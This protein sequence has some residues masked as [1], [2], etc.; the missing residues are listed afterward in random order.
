MDNKMTSLTFRLAPKGQHLI[1][2][3]GEM[4]GEQLVI[5]AE[6][7]FDGRVYPVKEIGD[8][9]FA[10]DDN[11]KSVI[12]NEVTFI[13][14]EAF[15][16]CKNLVELLFSAPITKIE[17]NAFCNCRNLKDINVPID[18]LRIGNWAFAYCENITKIQLSDNVREIGECAFT[19]CSKLEEINIPNLV[20]S[21]GAEAFSRCSSLSSIIIPDSV[22]Y[23]GKY[24]FIGCDNLK[25]VFINK[26]KMLR[27]TAVSEGVEILPIDAEY[28]DDDG[29]MNLQVFS[30]AMKDDE[31]KAE[32]IFKLAGE[33]YDRGYRK[34]GFALYKKAADLG[35]AKAQHIVAFCYQYGLGTEKDNGAALE[36]YQKAAAQGYAQSISYI[37]DF[38]YDGIAGI[39]RD[40]NMAVQLWKR[41]AE[42]GDKES[43]Y[44]LGNLY[45]NGKDVEQDREEAIRWYRRSAQQLFP[46][47]IKRMRELGEWIFDENENKDW[48]KPSYLNHPVIAFP[49]SWFS[50]NY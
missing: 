10:Y 45:Y 18:A 21:I 6:Q 23:T 17:D 31:M 8:S 33:F 14:H 5:P 32:E 9:A 3:G 1:V 2:T 47:A 15:A 40:T 39:K 12:M 27:D 38:Y 19:K 36:W 4:I 29:Q 50:D 34:R 25:K 35:Y 11:L 16:Y 30:K 41:A 13:G 49:E 20:H 43:Q 24:V 42:L 28:F 48:Y 46:R 26:P 22:T 7:A 37:A 44:V